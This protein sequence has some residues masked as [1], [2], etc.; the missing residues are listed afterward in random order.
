MVATAKCFVISGL[1]PHCMPV[2]TAVLP[3]RCGGAV[4][5]CASGPKSSLA[6]KAFSREAGIVLPVALFLL[7]AATLLTLALVKANMVSL[8]VGGASVLAA[9]AQA[10]S[11]RGLNNFLINN[12]VIEGPLSKRVIDTGVVFIDSGNPADTDVSVIAR[13]CSKNA[14]RSRK[15]TQYG[16]ATT[17]GNGVG[18]VGSVP[19]AFNLHQIRSVTDDAALG[20]HAETNAGITTMVADPGCPRP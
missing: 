12:A 4:N 19:M 14:P 9:E 6:M 20:I 2:K 17:A 7:V 13:N 10:D 5:M 3:R 16:A 1:K 18:G 8:R 11:E 15:P